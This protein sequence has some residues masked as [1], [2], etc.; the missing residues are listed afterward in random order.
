MTYMSLALDKNTKNFYLDRMRE[1]VLPRWCTAEDTATLLDCL[2]GL[3]G[4]N[5][6]TADRMLAVTV[7]AYGTPVTASTS[8]RSAQAYGTFSLRM[9]M[10]YILLSFMPAFLIVRMRPEG[11]LPTEEDDGFFRSMSDAAG[12]LD[13]EILDYVVAAGRERR[14]YS[15]K[16]NGTGPIPFPAVPKTNTGRTA[17]PM[18]A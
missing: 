16:N 2:Y 14:F 7:N 6:V 15:Y 17:P 12:A 8:G 5:P 4:I 18:A 10:I 13:I 9:T 3:P 1:T 11:V